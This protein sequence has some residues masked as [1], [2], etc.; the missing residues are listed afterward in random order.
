MKKNNANSLARIAEVV[1]LQEREAAIQFAGFLGK[2]N[3]HHQKIEELTRYRD[4]YSR[5][6]GDKTDARMSASDAQV[7][8]AFI[9]KL[10]ALIETMSS[11]GDELKE[12]AEESKLRWH[13][14]KSKAEGFSGLA[15]KRRQE[16]SQL[17]GNR[18][19]LLLEDAW[20]A[21]S[22]ANGGKS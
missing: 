10:N 1:A 3:A 11:Q 17:K 20:L 9:A 13:E 18:R 15:E 16:H 12:Q 4:E 6:L 5:Q 2:Y 14:I 19:S 22:V 7:L 21:R 8:A